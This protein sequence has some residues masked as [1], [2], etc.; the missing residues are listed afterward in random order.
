MQNIQL[1]KIWENVL[2]ELENRVS[3]PIMETW[4]AA[5]HPLALTGQELY[6]EVPD[7]FS[8]DWLIDR[9]S[10]ILKSIVY[11][12]LDRDV[13]VNFILSEEKE[14]VL[15]KVSQREQQQRQPLHGNLN[16]RYT[17]D[18]FVVGNSNR[19]AHAASLAIADSPAKTYNPFFIYGGVGLGKTHLMQAI[20]HHILARDSSCKVAYV[21]SETFTNELI[22]SIRD[23]STTEFRNKYRS[24][25]I[26]LVDDIQFL[27]NKERTQEEFFHTFNTLYE[28]NK[29]IIISSDRPP[30]EIPTLEDRL[31][32]RFEWGLITDIQPPD[33][34]TRI[35]ILSKK[36]QLENKE[37]PG[38]VLAFIAERIQS[39]IRQLE[40][41]LIRIIAYS[42]LHQKEIT[43]E[44]AEKVLKDVLPQKKVRPITG[45][46]ILKAVA[47][48]FNLKAEELR[49][50]RRSRNVAFP[51]QIGMYLCREL[52]DLS[53]PKIGELFGGRDHTTVLHACERI[54]AEKQL[55]P[56][57]EETLREIINK[58][59]DS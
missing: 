12:L 32:S 30:H 47:E 41:A 18:T 31:R 7:V 9:M 50:K 49:S 46:L 38:E 20:G 11:D 55:D 37:V 52:T 24:V 35:A 16:P 17:F 1:D 44:L 8:R 42:S 26:L 51:R 27:A 25:D 40:G 36:M 6:I 21:T 10:S 15:R 39:N 14:A 28:A 13:N 23:E 29:Q 48:H 59:K 22:A 58:L 19:F 56:S 5:M 45:Q 57:L 43:V 54:T 34:E 3:S 4:R 33:Y 53:Y 2:S